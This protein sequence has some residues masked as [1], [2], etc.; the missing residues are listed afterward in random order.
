MAL[1]SVPGDGF[2]TQPPAQ[3]VQ[4][5]QTL[6]MIKVGTRPQKAAPSRP[7]EK[8]SV[9]KIVEPTPETPLI[10][11]VVETEETFRE[12]VREDGDVE[13]GD[14]GYEEEAREGE[15][16]EGWA[17]EG[18]PEGGTMTDR[19]YEALLGYIKDFI[20]KKLVYQPMARRRNLEGVVGVHFEIER[21]GGLAAITVERSSGSSILDNAAVSLVKKIHPPENLTLNRTLAL[22]V[23]VTYELT[24]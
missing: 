9:E 2:R 11:E 10:E 3:E 12:A 18:V 13:E 16:G 15:G 19:E 23:N 8:E 20:E 24:E 5:I 7:I 4:F 21:N 14:R 22:M 6:K 1:I 17:T